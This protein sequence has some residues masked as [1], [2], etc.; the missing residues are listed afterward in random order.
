MNEIL[1]D[2]YTKQHNLIIDFYEKNKMR[3]KSSFIDFNAPQLE[4]QDLEYLSKFRK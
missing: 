3:I 4:K 2:T 1:F